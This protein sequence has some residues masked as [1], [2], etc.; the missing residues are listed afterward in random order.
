MAEML[1]QQKHGEFLGKT[2]IKAQI[3][4][5]FVAL[6]AA[7]LNFSPR[8]AS[9]MVGLPDEHAARQILTEASREFLT[10]LSDLPEKV[11]Q[12]ER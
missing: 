5:V 8:Y 3:G 10:E 4:D 2:R 12:R 7:I 1:A 9:R 6:R 11:F